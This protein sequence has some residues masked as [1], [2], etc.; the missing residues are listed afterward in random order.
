MLAK[1]RLKVMLPL[2]VH[3]IFLILFYLTIAFSII[4]QLGKGKSMFN[5]SEKQ[6]VTNDITA[7]PF[8][9]E[10]TV[11][12]KEGGS[13]YQGYQVTVTEPDSVPPQAEKEVITTTVFVSK[14]N[15]HK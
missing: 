14:S 9:H 11:I 6:V 2:G 10:E 5:C 1:T 3:V 7:L 13:N 15:N 8:G 12:T 4:L